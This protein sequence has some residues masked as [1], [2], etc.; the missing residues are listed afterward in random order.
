M[1]MRVIAGKYRHRPL[2]YP[3]SNPSIRPTKDRIREALFSILGP[4]EDKVFLDLY[5][6]SG[7]IGIEAISRGSKKTYFVDHSKEALNFVKK[8][9]ESLKID[10]EYE[11]LFMDDFVALEHLKNKGVKFD[12]IFIDPP[13]ELGKYEELLSYIY[14][15]DLVNPRSVIAMESNHKIDTNQ[16]LDKTI[17]EYHYGEITLTIIRS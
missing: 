15:N 7:S 8:N 13:Y 6:G 9:I 1:G 2:I 11:V 16:L 3:E 14:N 10:E 5:A 17:K 12:V 4:L